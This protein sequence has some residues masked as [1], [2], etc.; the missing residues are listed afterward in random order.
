[1]KWPV[2]GSK[3]TVK[4]L[5]REKWHD[6][7][8]IYKNEKRKGVMLG[9]NIGGKTPNDSLR[10]NSFLAK[11]GY[12]TGNLFCRKQSPFLNVINI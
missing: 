2:R 1:M 12:M 6:M 8:L 5:T 7:E 4:F 9:G 11:K 3:E 10:L